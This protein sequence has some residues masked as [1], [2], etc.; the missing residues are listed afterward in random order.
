MNDDLTVKQRDTLKQLRDDGWVAYYRG[1]RF[2]HHHMQVAGCPARTL[3][4]PTAADR[5]C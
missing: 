3:A 5:H 1:T 4:F 2:D